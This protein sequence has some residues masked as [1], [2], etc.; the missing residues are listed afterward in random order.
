MS[1]VSH[2]QMRHVT[3]SNESCLTGTQLQSHTKDLT[4]RTHINESCLTHSIESCDTFKWVMSHRHTAAVKN[5]TS[6]MWNTSKMSHV[7][8]IQMSHVSHIRGS[9]VS[10]AHCCSQKRNIWHVENVLLLLV[11]DMARPQRRMSSC[12]RFVDS[13]NVWHDSFTRVFPPEDEFVHQVRG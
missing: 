12:A 1:H 2:I 4:C 9:H 6:D 10:Q 8:H 3:H 11:L 5:E 13:S 7:P